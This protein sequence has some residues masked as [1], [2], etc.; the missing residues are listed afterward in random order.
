MINQ[1]LI[2]VGGKGSRLGEITKKI[3]KPLLKIN[4]KPFLDYLIKFLLKFKIKKIILLTKFK[5]QKFNKI[6]N[7]KKF[8][9]TKIKCIEEKEYLGT[10]GSLKNVIKKLDKKFILC[11]GDT[12]FD[13]NL[14][15]FNKKL[16]KNDIGILACSSNQKNIKRYSKFN[17]KGKKLVSSGIYLFQREKIKKYLIS[18]GSLENEVINKIPKNKFKKISYNKKF[19]DIGIP[20]DLFR[21]KKILKD[22]EKKKCVFLDRD[23]VINYDYGY[24]HRKEKFKWKKNVIKAIKL[25]N[26][27]GYLVIV[28]SNQSG[29]GRGFYSHKDV[30]KLHTWINKKLISYGAFIDRFYFAPYF[31]F[32]KNKKYRQGEEFRK[33]NTGMFK[34]AM[35]DFKIDKYNSYFIGDNNGDK[36]AA[37]KFKIKYFNVD[38]NTDLYSLIKKK[39]NIN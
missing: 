5:Y 35:K 36:K 10:S 9:Q 2:L 20:K 30:E 38:N 8:G 28:I 32:S 6:Y 24:V 33:P 7:G 39:L 37:K 13:I 3:P 21:A 11:N 25:L 1:A 15:D 16:K 34:K 17:C 27:N 4:D 18:P 19:I 12:I 23:G 29:I 22:L 31:K 26:D 14:F